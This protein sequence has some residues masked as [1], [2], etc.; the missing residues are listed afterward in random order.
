[1]VQ[2][3]FVL[4][5]PAGERAREAAAEL[6]QKMGLTQVLVAAM[7]TAAEGYTFFVVY[8]RTEVAVDFADASTCP[9]W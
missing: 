4:P 6:A 5:V 1:M 8:G 7:E 9:R 3:S 2:L